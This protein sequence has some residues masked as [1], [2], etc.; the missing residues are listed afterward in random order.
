LD[1]DGTACA[2][3][4]AI[5]RVHARGA[6]LR[7]LLASMLVAQWRAGQYQ[8][9][10]GRRLQALTSGASATVTPGWVLEPGA[11][12]AELPPTRRSGPAAALGVGQA[13]SDPA[14]R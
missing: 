5:V 3:T 4:M 11:P 6:G 7:E 13:G 12:L 2:R 14:C 1:D 8:T 10:Q 9:E